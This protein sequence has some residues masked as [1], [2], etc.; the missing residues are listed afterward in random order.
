M[1]R[2]LPFYVKTKSKT[3]VVFPDFFARARCQKFPLGPSALVM[4]EH[5]L[6]GCFHRYRGVHAI[7]TL[8]FTDFDMDSVLVGKLDASP[9]QP[10]ICSSRHLSHYVAAHMHTS[11][12]LCR[13]WILPTILS[14]DVSVRFMFISLCVSHKRVVHR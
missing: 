6:C 7:A 11:L 9:S 4:I 2:K 5:I 8:N 14:R 3:S 12:H 13:S 10:R 1:T